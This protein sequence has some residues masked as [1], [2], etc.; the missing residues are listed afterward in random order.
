MVRRGSDHKS[1][2][3]G[4]IL[5]RASRRIEFEPVAVFCPETGK[6][7]VSFALDHPWLAECEAVVQGDLVLISIYVLQRDIVVSRDKN[8][9]GS[10][11]DRN[12]EP[13]ANGLINPGEDTG[14]LFLTAEHLPYLRYASTYPIDFVQALEKWHYE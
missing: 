12:A 4:S 11:F 8:S 6:R 10:H 2:P 13:N 1:I 3:A 14:E 9:P 5:Y 7:G